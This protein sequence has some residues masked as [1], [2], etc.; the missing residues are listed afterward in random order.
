MTHAHGK[1]LPVKK[2]CRAEGSR[3]ET[4]L[5]VAEKHPKSNSVSLL[6]RDTPVLGG[7]RPSTQ[8]LSGQVWPEGPLRE[9]RGGQAGPRR[10]RGSAGGLQ[11]AFVALD[12]ALLCSG[13]CF[14]RSPQGRSS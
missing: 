13:Q 11:G 4:T 7:L 14:P 2:G 6:T 12:A 3:A 1:H 10:D 5:F 8:A 9:Q